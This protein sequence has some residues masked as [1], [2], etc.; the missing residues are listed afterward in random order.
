MSIEISSSDSVLKEMNK[1]KI[2]HSRQMEYFGFKEAQQN[3]HTFF[4]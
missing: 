3:L 1:I 4:N 2:R